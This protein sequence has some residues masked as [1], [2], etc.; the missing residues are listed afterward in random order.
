MIT[1]FQDVYNNLESLRLNDMY[2]DFAEEELTN[3][4]SDYNI[5]AFKICHKFEEKINKPVYLLFK[6]TIC[7]VFNEEKVKSEYCPNCNS[8]LENI[9]KSNLCWVKYS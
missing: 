5:L 8:K 6:N 2:P 9:K 4:K 3:I 1:Y 7:E